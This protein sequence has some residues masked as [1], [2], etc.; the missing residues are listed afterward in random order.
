[1][2]LYTKGLPSTAKTSKANFFFYYFRLRVHARNSFQGWL[3]HLLLHRYG[4][5]NVTVSINILIAFSIIENR[6]PMCT[7]KRCRPK[8][9]SLGVERRCTPGQSWTNHC[10]DCF[11][12]ETGVGVC[13][14]RGCLQSGSFHDMLR[15]KTGVNSYNSSGVRLNYTSQAWSTIFI[16][17]ILILN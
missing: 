6:E 2:V 16:I 4:L 10:N 1:M 7:Q 15:P 13:T 11:C 3:Q 8:K 14:L 5:I 17:I 9:R 12:T